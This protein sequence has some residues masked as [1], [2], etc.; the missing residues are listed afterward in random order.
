MVNMEDVALRAQVSK[1]TVSRVFNG[2]PNVSSKTRDRVLAAC[3]ELNYKLNSSIQDLLKKSRSGF[4]A[5]IAFV[6]VDRDFSDPAYVELVNPMAE[7]AIKR[8]LHLML[9]KLDGT[10]KSVYD[11][12]PVLRDERVDGIL[13]S[14]NINPNTTE[15]LE[16][17]GIHTVIIGRYDSR[18]SRNFNTV[19]MDERRVILKAIDECFARGAQRL[20]FVAEDR[21]RLSDQTNFAIYKD[22]LELHEKPLDESIC[23]WGN[24]WHQGIFDIM[25][26]VFTRPEL[27]FDAVMAIDFRIANEVCHLFG[28]HYGVRRELYPYI[29]TSQKLRYFNLLGTIIPVNDE[30]SGKVV[31]MAM[32]ILETLQNGAQVPITTIV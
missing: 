17:L 1:A 28:C 4:T 2:N 27:P 20:A 13:L 24:G 5:N 3:D 9:V 26:D 6:L 15:A 8:H 21:N 7:E 16:K 19:Y 31:H 22:A 30:F 12:P 10:E 14:G 18:I 25:K 23:Y 11:L 32:N 29:V